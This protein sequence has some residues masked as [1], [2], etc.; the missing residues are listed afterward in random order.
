M[1]PCS[2]LIVILVLW[3]IGS[4]VMIMHLLFLCLGDLLLAFVTIRTSRAKQRKDGGKS[5]KEA[6]RK[7]K[8]DF[9]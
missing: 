5:W 8:R 9:T 7:I 4:I 3:E 1:A 2:L 6:K